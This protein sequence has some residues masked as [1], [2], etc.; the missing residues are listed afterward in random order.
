[1]ELISVA[2]KKKVKAENWLNLKSI[3]VH[4]RKFVYV[5]ITT[6]VLSS[7]AFEKEDYVGE[8]RHNYQIV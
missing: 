1:M 8:Y 5:A 2:T 3:D 4:G 6:N 7:L